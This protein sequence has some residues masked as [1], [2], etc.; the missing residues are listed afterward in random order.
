MSQS[1]ATA[2]INLPQNATRNV[3]NVVLKEKIEL[4][5]AYLFSKRSYLRL[6]LVVSDFK[7]VYNQN[8]SYCLLIAIDFSYSCL[9]YRNSYSK[10]CH[11]HGLRS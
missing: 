10:E 1:E 7:N 2:T 8:L 5:R 11:L 4:N 9:D 3:N 6:V